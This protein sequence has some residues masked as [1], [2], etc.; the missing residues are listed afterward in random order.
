MTSERGEFETGF[1]R[2]SE[3]KA[4]RAEFTLLSEPYCGATN[5]SIITLSV[6]TLNIITLHCTWYYDTL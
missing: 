2:T 1:K 4:S 3:T 5:L 6:T